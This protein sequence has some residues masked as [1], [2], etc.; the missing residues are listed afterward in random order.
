MNVADILRARIGPKSRRSKGQSIVEFALVVPVMLLLLGG[1]IDLGRVF[2]SQ[3]AITDSAREGALWA[4]QHPGSWDKGCDDTQPVSQA[5]PNQVICHAFGETTGGFATVTAADV[6]CSSTAPPTVTPCAGGSPAQGGSVWLTVRGTFRLV[7]GGATVDLASTAIGRIAQ[8]P[9]GTAPSAQTITF[10][11]IPDQVL[12]VG[13]ITV[14]ASASSGL[15]VTF[16]T[17]TPTVCTASGPGGSTILIDAVG[18]CSITAFQDGNGS[19]AAAD[20]VAQSFNV[21]SPLPP[22]PGGQT[23]TFGPLADRIL[24]S[25]SFTVA[26]T[27]SSGLPVSFTTTTPSICTS[28]GTNGSVINPIA[29]GVCTVKADQAGDAASTPPYLPAP[30]V[31]QSFTVTSAASVCVA[32]IARFMVTPLSGVADKGS[33]PGTL[34]TFDGN[35]TTVQAACHPVW[36]WTFGVGHGTTNTPNQTTYTYPNGTKSGTYD[37]TLVVTVD[38]N[39]SNSVV[40]T[41]GIN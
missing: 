26:A 22:P 20:P 14:S 21:T 1:A 7:M 18:I 38:G 32:P 5:N 34:F 36:S 29:V 9:A 25:G 16:T 39:L 33:T 40:H 24:G 19:F 31:S 8:V 12:G 6:I 37:V 2:Y 27:A 41:V 11:A 23:I 15:P 4:V 30:S 35:A 10:P 17:T 3:I 13:P 28:S